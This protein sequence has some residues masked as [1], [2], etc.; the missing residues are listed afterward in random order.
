MTV[1]RTNGVALLRGM[2]RE[3]HLCKTLLR[4]KLTRAFTICALS[5]CGALSGVLP[6]LAAAP[7][8]AA[9]GPIW[10]LTSITR[11][12]NL[13]P[14]S[15]NREVLVVATNVGGAST[16]GSTITVGDVLP[17]HIAAASVSGR[18]EYAN[19]GVSGGEMTCAALPTISCTQSR[20]ADPGDTLV[21]SLSVNVANNASADEVSHVTA[22]GGGGEAVAEDFRLPVGT[23]PAGFGLEQSGTSASLSTLQA[24]AHPNLTT[25]FNFNT[26]SPSEPSAPVKDVRFDLPV[27]LVGNTVGMPQCSTQG[28]LEQ[29]VNGHSCPTDS[30]VGMEATT[31]TFGTFVDPVYNIAPAPGE[32]AA[33][34]FEAINELVR[35]DT[36]VLTGGTYG[37]RVTAK[38][39]SEESQVFGTSI[40]IWGV[41]ADHNGPGDDYFG[42]N[43]GSVGFGGPSGTQRV[44]LLTNPTR[45][46]TPLDGTFSTDAWTDIGKFVSLDVPMGTPIGCGSL[47]FP[48]SVSMLPDTLEAGAPAGYRFDLKVQQNNSPEALATSNVKDVK[49]TLPAGTVV[50]PSAAHGLK[51]CSNALFALHSDGVGACPREAQVGTIEIHSP[52]IPLPLQGQVFL[53]EPECNPCTPADAEDG[54]MVRL[55]LQAIGEGESGILVKLEGHGQI[56]QSTGRI[57]TVFEDN[58][59][60]P[61]DELKLT[62]SG[63]PRAVLVNPRTCGVVRT[64]VHLTPWGTPLTPD[65]NPFSEFEVNQNCFGLQ[66]SPSFVAGTTNI[67]AG[68]YS[69]F[70][71]SFGRH[72][73]DQFLG[74]LS[75]SMPPGLLGNIGSVPLCKEPEASQGTCGAGSLIGHVQV[76]TGPGAD[77][78]LVSGG[79]VF[80]TEGYGG[81]PYGLSI[82]VP[83]VAGPYTLAG[84]TGHGTVVVRAKIAVDET[85]AAITVTSDPL[86]NMLDGIPLQLKLVDVTIDRPAFTFNPTNC[87][88][89]AIGASISSTAGTSAN[90]ASQFQVTNCATLAFKPL[91]KVS[92]QG[93]TSRKNG[94]S[95]DVKLTY[96]KAP[97]GSQANIRAVK[98]ALPKQLPSRLST[99]QKACP[100]ATFNANPAACPST[101]IVG[102][103]TART[104][105]LAKALAGP[106]YFVSHAGLK[107]P[108]LVIVLSGS[109]VTIHLSGETFISKKGVT[110]STFRMVPDVPVSAFE[111]KLPQGKY[112]ALAANVNLCTAKLAM[113]T[114]FVGQ[115]G[116]EIH[117]STPIAVT[118]CPKRKKAKAARG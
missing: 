26:L 15:E 53:A 28:V 73:N 91:F 113:P 64:D 9:T 110:S 78:F 45:C 6:V 98:V 17:A 63:G 36:G 27:G 56:D 88:K 81:A 37:V 75:L 108:E 12:T 50:N 19:F 30:I 38:D 24:G 4:G 116:A 93:K 5:A 70:T 18:D 101:S 68:E 83:A 84:T 87:A 61:F 8:Q 62:L 59:Q 11:P 13:V 29:V 109:G 90:V 3:T 65:S 54:R 104:P 96:P 42:T 92:T 99:L 106:A 85:T 105:I 32:P 1:S 48:A 97:W 23:T 76:L 21:I 33:F 102:T 58:P 34:E 66:F 117:T 55:F 72:D 2:L 86:P 44:P 80:L 51:A 49:V 20:V 43:A 95:L 16:D 52:N 46:G 114:A 57:T 25:A 94:A 77:P 115:N 118:S 47:P 39:V 22:K 82:V 112:S 79:Q 31:V 69:P 67:Q 89:R 74:G 107:F 14:G 41:P 60:L 35:I 100:D 40:T 10:K 103:A 71:L 111:L 7:A